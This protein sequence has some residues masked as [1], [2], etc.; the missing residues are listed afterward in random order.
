LDDDGKA[1][2]DHSNSTKSSSDFK[3]SINSYRAISHRFLTKKKTTSHSNSPL[4]E[5]TKLV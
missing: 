3:S 2:D 5:A 4:S 1:I